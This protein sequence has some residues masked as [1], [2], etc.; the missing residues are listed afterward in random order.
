MTTLLTRDQI[1]EADDRITE[2]VDVP[3]WGG[4]VRIRSLAGVE[5]DQYEAGIT[6]VRWE[7]TKPSVQSNTQN[8]RARLV[9][10]TAIDED[11][12]SVFSEKDVLILGQKSA[13]AL[14]RCFKV[15]QR[16][17]GLSDEDVEALKEQLGNAQSDGSGSDSPETSA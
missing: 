17:S 10:M 6:S 13:A 5:R 14:E 3:E 15:A 7:G 4:T 9:A 11:G 1:L 8:I 12:K 16:L 2:D